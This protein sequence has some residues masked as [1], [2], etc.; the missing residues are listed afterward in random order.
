MKKFFA[1]ILAVV[2]ILALA[3]C[4]GGSGGTQ[5]QST[6]R[7]DTPTPAPTPVEIEG[8]FFPGISDDD[9]PEDLLRKAGSVKSAEFKPSDDPDFTS[10]VFIV[11]ADAPMH[12]YSILSDHYNVRAISSELPLEEDQERFYFFEWGEVTL[13][14]KELL[15]NEGEI[16]I[17]AKIF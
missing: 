16:H 15:I 4:G 10:E 2:M 7:P 1:L 5:T 6:P 8:E 14:N 12:F 13:S 11:L 17:H 3:A 9:I